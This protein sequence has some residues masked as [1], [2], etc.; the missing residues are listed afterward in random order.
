MN[1]LVKLR[2]RTIL[3]KA[4][5][6]GLASIARSTGRASIGDIGPVLNHKIYNIIIQVS[7][8]YNVY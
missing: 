4:S 3:P 6:T 5:S 2:Q 1:V 7:N 8:S